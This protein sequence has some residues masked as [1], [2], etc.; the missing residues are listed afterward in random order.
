MIGLGAGRNSAMKSSLINLVAGLALAAGLQTAATA[1]AI[2][3]YS[4]DQKSG[5]APNAGVITDAHGTNFGTGVAGG[6]GNCFSGLGCGTVFELLPPNGGGFWTLKVLHD[7]QDAQDGYLPE[8]L[9]LGP[10]GS[11]F[12]SSSNDQARRHG[13]VFQLLP[14]AKRGER[15]TFQI[16]YTFTGKNDGELNVGSPLIL[17]H[18][19]LYGI[20]YGGSYACGQ[21]RCG[22]VFRLSAPALGSGPW[23]EKTLYKFSGGATS[24]LPTSIVGFGPQEALYL[25]TAL[26]NGA[27]VELAPANG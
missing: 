25:S 27:V 14:P 22:S 17:H 3:L 21:L 12:G 11:V 26:G 13:T 2:S 8:A 7:F 19:S 16:L 4:L 24:G 18:N 10:N 9:T 20:A 15:W 23:T 5:F 1:R 6:N